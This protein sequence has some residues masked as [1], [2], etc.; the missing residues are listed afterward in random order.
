MAEAEHRQIRD[1]R[2]LGYGRIA[3]PA[4]D[5]RVVR[6]D[7][8]DPAGKADAVER[9]DQPPADRRLF[10]STEDGDRFRPEQRVEP[11]PDRSRR[12]AATTPRGGCY[13]AAAGATSAAADLLNSPAM[14]KAK[15][16]DPVA[17]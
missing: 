15:L 9:G 11:H 17:D 2:R 10:G 6:V 5:G 13:E 8:K 1:F 7:R 3:R 12:G 14:T 4:E 16:A